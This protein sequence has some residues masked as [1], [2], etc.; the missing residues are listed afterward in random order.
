MTAMK[1]SLQD[2]WV[3]DSTCFGCGPANPNGLRLRSF[4]LDGGVVAEWHPEPHHNAIPVFCAVV[5]L[6]LSS[7]ATP[8]RPLPGR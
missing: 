3:P 1:A 4:P 2:Q 6:A 5:S 8:A 7:T